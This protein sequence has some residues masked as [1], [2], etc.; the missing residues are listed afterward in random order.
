[1][2]SLG[3]LSRPPRSHS[4]SNVLVYGIENLPVVGKDD[5]AFSPGSKTMIT[6]VADIWLALTTL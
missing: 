5:S 1:M 4:K 2:R 3:G 6:K